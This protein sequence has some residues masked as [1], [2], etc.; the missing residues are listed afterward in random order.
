MSD[1]YWSQVRALLHCEGIN[2]STRIVD[3]KS[4]IFPCSGNASISTLQKKFGS[5]S[6]YFDGTGD[7]IQVASH[8]DFKLGTS[9]FTV[10]GFLYPRD[11]AN[12][13]P[14][15]FVFDGIGAVLQSWLFVDP[16]AAAGKFA[17]FVGS[18]STTVPHLVSTSSVVYGQWVHVAVTRSN[19]TWRL[20]INGVLEATATSS[21][22]ATSTANS[23]AQFFLSG[24]GGSNNYFG[25]IDEFR[26]TVGVCRY[27]ADFTVPT[28][29]YEDGGVVATDPYYDKV[30][31]HSHFDGENNGTS[32]V[33]LKGHPVTLV[34][35][36]KTFTGN[37]AAAGGSSL[38]LP[39]TSVTNLT[40]SHS[41]F[42][43]GTSDFTI[44]GFTSE[45]AASS[46]VTPLFTFYDATGTGYGLRV[47][48]P[49]NSSVAGFGITVNGTVVTGS[50][51]T[52][53]G[54]NAT[55]HFA[56]CREGTTLTLFRNGAKIY[57]VE[58][59]SV[60]IS[61]N[62]T[63]IIGR[64]SSGDTQAQAHYYDEW[65]VTKGIARYSKLSATY[66]VPAV[67]FPEKYIKKMT[68]TVRDSTGNQISRTVRAY[69]SSDGLL[70]DVGVSDPTT[71][72]FSLAATDDT[73]H[74]VVVHDPAKNALVYDHITPVIV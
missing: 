41:D 24:S 6:L 65:R 33:D 7:Y 37:Y 73:E 29:P 8:A 34:G 44:E 49:Q 12:A 55:S 52:T 45:A 13:N 53:W 66:T 42:I 68:G 63:F 26:L 67:P 17:F 74:F 14:A 35:D 59:G 16:S 72:A 5:S 69:R 27:T 50:V 15:A 32:V 70:T 4:H 23:T 71:G 61:C 21:V 19:T 30:I 31:F 48:Y 46:V 39:T 11:T 47:V 3:E 43:L 28:A 10:E 25:Y 9:D 56:F 18:V 62:G 2:G 58:I 64:P 38:L 57:S 22:A 60:S 40:L 51:T 20:F 54:V 1:P 36:A